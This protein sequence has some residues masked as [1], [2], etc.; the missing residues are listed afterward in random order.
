[1]KSYTFVFNERLQI[2]LPELEWTWD[3]Y[4]SDEQSEILAR[5]EEIRGR[6]PDQIIAF[7]AEINEKQEKLNHEENFN[8]SCAL[9]TEI[10]E[11]ASKINDLHLYYRLNQQVGAIKSH[12]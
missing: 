2:H 9:N 11:I 5:W 6:I 1:M 4:T 3:H 7:E 8:Q 10:S 12:Q